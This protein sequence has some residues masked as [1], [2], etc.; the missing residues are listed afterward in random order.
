MSVHLASLLRVVEVL[1]SCSRLLSLVG[2]LL[3]MAV[4]AGAT[5]KASGCCFLM[6]G[7]CENGRS[8]ARSSGLVYMLADNSTYIMEI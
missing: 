6:L 1:S 7:G 8:L 3:S 2:S 5:V 4:S